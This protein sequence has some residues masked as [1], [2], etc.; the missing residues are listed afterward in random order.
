MKRARFFPF[1]HLLLAQGAGAHA[2]RHGGKMASPPTEIARAG[3]AKGVRRGRALAW[4]SEC[5][6]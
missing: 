6:A 4:S 3:R 1:A 2:L 5:V